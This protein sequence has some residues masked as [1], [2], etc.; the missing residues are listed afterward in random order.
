MMRLS[1]ALFRSFRTFLTLAGLLGGLAVAHVSAARAADSAVILMYHRFGDGRYPT[2]NIRLD[3]FEAH[4]AELKSGG[5]TVLPVPDIVKAIQD[6]TPLPD[7]TVGITVDDAYESVFKEAWPRLKAAGFPW[8]LFVASGPV[9]SGSD[10]Y[11]DWQQ[12]KALADSGVTIG[13]QAVNHPHMAG[14]DEARNRKELVDSAAR[15]EQM[16][17][18]RPTLFAYPFGE[19]GA[20]LM[21]QVADTGYVAAFG[22]HSGAYDATSPGFYIPR[23]PL[24]ENFGDIDRFKQVAKALALPVVD[25]T[26]SDPLLPSK[27]EG[28]PPAF[29]FT[30][31]KPLANAPELMA[32][33]HSD[34]GKIGDIQWLGS[35]RV[36]IRFDRPFGPG[37]T[38]INCTMP[39]PDGR[40][41]W[42]GT[43]FF[44]PYS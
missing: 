4:I 40:W 7:K 29:G 33:Y 12:V 27:G 16:T 1:C 2:T 25:V 22:Q 38:R 20:R 35:Q 26:P 11:M 24:N 15:I 31:A 44:V 5:Y 43:Q 37:R 30:L 42:Y 10:E 14:R 23:F 36:E 17:G 6:G 39:G 3:Q 41:R 9:D 34:F 8:T 21:K 28:N 13:S 32:C 19:A 18:K